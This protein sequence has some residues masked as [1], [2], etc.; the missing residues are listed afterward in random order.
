MP[1][2]QTAITVSSDRVARRR[3]ITLSTALG[4]ILAIASLQTL[5]EKA[6]SKTRSISRPVLSFA[7]LL[8]LSDQRE[9]GGRRV[10]DRDRVRGRDK[11]RE[12]R[13]KERD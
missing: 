4:A 5:C 2:W 7:Y 8:L 13:G 11:E 3:V 6:T 12:R 9:G 1:A 10:R